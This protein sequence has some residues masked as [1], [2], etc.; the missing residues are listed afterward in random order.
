ML[1]ALVLHEMPSIGDEGIGQLSTLKDLRTLDIWAMEGVTDKSVEVISQL[2]NIDTLSIR[3]TS[4]TDSS[5]DLILK[6][7]KL[8]NL[9]LKGN[10]GVTADGLKKFST[11]KFK[12]L[13]AQ[14]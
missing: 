9:T 11:K 13:V 10:T 2:P 1:K 14:P 7:P 6:M 12:K 3:D 8:Q 4:I 5:I